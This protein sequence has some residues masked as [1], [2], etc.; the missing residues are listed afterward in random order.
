MNASDELNESPDGSGWNDNAPLNMN[1][2][3]GP[4]EYFIIEFRLHVIHSNYMECNFAEEEAVQAAMLGMQIDQSQGFLPKAS[5]SVW[6]RSH[7]EGSLEYPGKGSRD[8]N[9]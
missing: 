7:F 2:E 8:P 4:E 1:A 9:G 3:F 5:K 6:Q